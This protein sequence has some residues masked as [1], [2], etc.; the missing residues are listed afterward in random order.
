MFQRYDC[1]CSLKSVC[2]LPGGWC[3][4]LYKSY[5]YV[6]LHRVGFLS[7]FGLKTGINFAHFSLESGMAFEGTT[8][9]YERICRT[10]YK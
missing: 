5:K 1:N 3:S 9:V 6:Q 4:P 2:Q 7:R 8:A 10:N